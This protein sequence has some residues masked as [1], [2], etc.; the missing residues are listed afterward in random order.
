MLYS[1]I[2]PDVQSSPRVTEGW[3]RSQLDEHFTLVSLEHG[4]DRNRRSAWFT[5]EKLD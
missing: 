2:N 1:W 4:T 5:F 3:L